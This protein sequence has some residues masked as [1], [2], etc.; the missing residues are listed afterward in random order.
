M[1]MEMCSFVGDDGP[2][3][4]IF[5]LVKLHQ[6]MKV[7]HKKKK[8]LQMINAILVIHVATGGG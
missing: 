6:N 1:K 8:R 3:L 4:S 2:R 7:E 5:T